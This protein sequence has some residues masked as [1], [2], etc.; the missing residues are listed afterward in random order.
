MNSRERIRIALSHQE[1]DRVPYDLGALGP[2]G[3][4]IQ[5][6]RNLLKYLRLDEKGEVGDIA[7]QRAKL[8]ESFLQ[9]FRVDTRSF[10]VRPQ[11]SWSLKMQEEEGYSLFY[12]EWGIGR[13][14]AKDQG[15][16]FFISYQPLSEVET[17]ALSR[18]PWP[19]PLD[20]NRLAGAENEIVEVRKQAD[21]AFVLGSSFSSG[22]LQFGAQLEGH[23]RFFTDLLLDPRRAE[24][25]LDKLL[26][27][28][29]SFY[30][31][32]LD[33]M[34]QWVDIVCEMDDFGH[35]HSL[36]ISAEMFRKL[37]K[38]RYAELFSFIKKR[39]GKKILLHSDGAI[40]PLIPDI[41]EMGVE[42]L[43]P[44][45][46][47]AKDMG[48]THKLKKEFGDSLTF[49]GGGADIQHILPFSTPQEVEDEVRRRIDDLAPGGGFVFAA[50]QAIQPE[51]P[52]ENIMAM[53][54]TLQTYGIYRGNSG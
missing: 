37:I 6:Y 48:D 38:P 16:H 30:R 28:K 39:Y 29:L 12:D 25:I 35:Q 46:V 26:Q 9:R 4:S 20:P 34:G 44:I 41:I 22:L 32:V 40:Y 52:P 42:I 49:W 50:T 10:R 51:T 23:E 1:P 43:N 24:W 33:Q 36:W 27:L 14:M 7:S 3:I 18:F 54:R 8:S 53:W 5:A 31:N 11:A 17:S 19:D 15:Q 45:Q 47:G 13:K 2:S 21:P